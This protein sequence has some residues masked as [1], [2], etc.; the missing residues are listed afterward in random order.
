MTALSKALV[1]YVETFAET[2]DRECA[3]AW[4]YLSALAAWAEDHG[5][6]SPRLRAAALPDRAKHFKAKGTAVQWLRSAISAL[7]V[8][9]GTAC[10]TDARYT[11]YRDGQPSEAHALALLDWW[12]HE[13]PPLAYDTVE[14][15]DTIDGFEV[16]DLRQALLDEDTQKRDGVVYTP[17]E[18]VDFQIEMTLE[19]IEK[20]FPGRAPIFMDPFCGTG[21]YPVRSARRAWTWHTGMSGRDALQGVASTVTGC[22]MDP[23]SA[24]VARLRLVAV[25]GDLAYTAGLTVS[26]RLDQAPRFTPKIAVGDTF[27]AGCA[28]AEEYALARPRLAVIQNLGYPNVDWEA[29]W[30]APPFLDKY[31]PPIERTRS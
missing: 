10:L 25:V 11:R 30:L 26:R 8:H 1:G 17:W 31:M 3:V 20:R 18:V 21:H 29:P 15:P 6:V 9:P 19:S 27:L 13:A 22:E 28:P 4:V 23:L 2:V 24:A 5:L 12:A 16:G 14:G 7:A